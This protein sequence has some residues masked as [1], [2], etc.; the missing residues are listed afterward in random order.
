MRSPAAPA[1]RVRRRRPGDIINNGADD[2]GSGTVTLMALAKAFSRGARMK[3]SLLFVWHTSE[4]GG[5]SG[6]RYMADHAVGAARESVR[7]TEHRHGRAEQV[8]RPEGSRHGVC[9]RGRIES[10]PSCTT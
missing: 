1:R 7:A 9:G 6:S 4:E 10:A 3:R 2:D 5:L 8:R